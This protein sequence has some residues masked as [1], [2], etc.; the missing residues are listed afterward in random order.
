[1]ITY[2]KNAHLNVSNSEC[3]PY[4][5]VPDTMQTLS[6]NEYYMG[7]VIKIVSVMSLL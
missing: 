2:A 5:T 3:D 1:M 7:L 4:I 6:H